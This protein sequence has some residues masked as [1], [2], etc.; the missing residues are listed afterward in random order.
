MQTES[1]QSLPLQAVIKSYLYKEYSDDDDLQAFVDSFNE[2]TQGYL[3][4]FNSTALS[5]YTSPSISGALL[6]WIG[7][8]IYGMP[9]PV[10]A[11]SDQQTFAGYDER[12]YNTIPYNDLTLISS[13]TAQ[14]AS[15]DIYNR[16]LTWNLYRSEER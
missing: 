10:L 1:F 8:G 5:V 16:A 3:D 11:T 4:W 12:T 15:D 9:R 6:D 7:L 2:I 13:G 14:V